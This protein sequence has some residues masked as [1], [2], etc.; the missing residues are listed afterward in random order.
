MNEVQNE[1]HELYS[2]I[3]ITVLFCCDWNSVFKSFACEMVFI[4]LPHRWRSRHHS[5]K[6]ELVSIMI[7]E[8][9]TLNCMCKSQSCWSGGAVS[10]YT[11]NRLIQITKKDVSLFHYLCV[12]WVASYWSVMIY[13]RLRFPHLNN[14]KNYYSF[15]CFLLSHLFAFKFNLNQRKFPHSNKWKQDKIFKVFEIVISANFRVLTIVSLLWI[16][17]FLLITFC[18]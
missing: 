1:H 7:F 15:V 11:P 8:L 4:L 17:V 9:E 10:Q 3:C 18:W 2:F 13:F 16:T 12:N 6:C 5:L 14:T